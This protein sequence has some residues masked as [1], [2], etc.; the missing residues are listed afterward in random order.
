VNFAAFCNFSFL[1]EFGGGEDESGAEA[2]EIR[3][4]EVESGQRG[5]WGRKRCW[6]GK[7]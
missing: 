5:S 3:L 7:G 1:R 6:G 4:R 2:V